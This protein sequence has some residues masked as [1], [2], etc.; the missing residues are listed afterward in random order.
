MN[1]PPQNEEYIYY[2]GRATGTSDK[3]VLRTEAFSAAIKNIEE[4]FGGIIWR[5]YIE[6]VSQFYDERG[7]AY[8]VLLGYPLRKHYY[9]YHKEKLQERRCRER[10]DACIGEGAHFIEKGKFQ[11]AVSILSEAWR[12]TQEEDLKKFIQKTIQ[13]FFEETEFRLKPYSKLASTYSEYEQEIVFQLLLKRGAGQ[14]LAG[15]PVSVFFKTGSGWIQPSELATDKNGGGK[16]RIRQFNRPGTQV[17][18]IQM[19]DQPDFVTPPGR[20]L[21]FEVGGERRE[22]GRTKYLLRRGE[23]KEEFFLFE[24]EGAPL[25]GLRIAAGIDYDLFVKLAL[26]PRSGSGEV[27]ERFEV[28]GVNVEKEKEDQLTIPPKEPPDQLRWEIDFDPFLLVAELE[29]HRIKTVQ[30]P[31]KGEIGIFDFVTVSIR[32]FYK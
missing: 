28:R 25:A 9:E 7:R 1:N 4:Q 14:P 21:T 10:V 24:K 3:I 6:T 8:Y 31:E 20:D 12:E 29:N 13:E 23:R 19:K 27:T 15:L 26:I 32:F 17:V 16:F 22:I 5:E 18:R 30:H 11:D 2:V